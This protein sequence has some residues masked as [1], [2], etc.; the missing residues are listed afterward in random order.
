VDVDD[1]LFQRL[2]HVSTES[3]EHTLAFLRDD[4]ARSAVM[5]LV[6]EGGSLS[7]EGSRV[8]VQVVMAQDTDHFDPAL[9][10]VETAVLL[11]HLHRVGSA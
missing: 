5:D 11:H 2:V 10:E 4:D 7:I 8:H 3:K 1:E 6:G 9:I